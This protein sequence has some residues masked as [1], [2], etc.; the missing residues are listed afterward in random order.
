LDIFKLPNNIIEQGVAM[1][2]KE[3]GDEGI[4]TDGA[5]LLRV[6]QALMDEMTSLLR[7]MQRYA[8]PIRPSSRKEVAAFLFDRAGLRETP[9]RSVAQ[10]HLVHLDHP[11]LPL[12]FRHSTVSRTLSLIRAMYPFVD[13]MGRVHTNWIPTNETS[14]RIYCDNFNVQQLPIPGR[15]GIVPDPGN[16]FMMCDSKHNELRVLAGLSKSKELAEILAS[17]DPHRATYSRMTGVPVDQITEEQRETGKAYGYGPIYGMDASGLAMRVGCSMK[18]AQ[19]LLEAYF[20]AMPGVVAY[21]RRVQAEAIKTHQVVNIFGHVRTINDWSDHG[22]A[23]RQAINTMIQGTAASIL[24][25][26]ILRVNIIE[27]V[28]F[29]ATVHDSILVQFPKRR[30]EELGPKVLKAMEYS[31]NGIDFPV[32]YAYG[33]SWGAVQHAL[34]GKEICVY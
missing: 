33:N 27:G 31:L 5:L 21:I 10:K 6:E 12:Y 1:T 9:Q 25:R 16:I 18:E 8:G 17:S 22:K 28:T 32:D 2:L 34:K 20:A 11:F 29:N 15:Y 4:L 19:E 24:K 7:E 3:A 13:E 23:E 26:M 14:G 30:V